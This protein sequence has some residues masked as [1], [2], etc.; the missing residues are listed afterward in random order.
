MSTRWRRDDPPVHGYYLATWVCGRG[1][2]IVSEL[3][4]NPTGGGGKKWWASRGYF[5]QT[6][7]VSVDG[8]IAW[9]PLPK[10]AAK[11]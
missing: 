9:M 7:G 4:F 2:G 6:T 1:D 5:S 8:V 10:P 11:R 3:W